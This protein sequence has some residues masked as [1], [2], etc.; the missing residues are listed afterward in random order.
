MRTL[1]PLAKASVG[2]RALSE[3]KPFRWSYLLTFPITVAAIWV[4][5]L[6]LAHVERAQLL[7][8]LNARITLGSVKEA[9]A[10][11]R[12][13]GRMPEPPLETFVAAAASPTRQ[14]AQEAQ[15]AISE[16]LRKWQRQLNADRNVSRVAHRL[17]RLAATLDAHRDSF[18]IRDHPWL[19]K[20]TER[21]VRLANTAPPEDALGLAVHCESLL[22]MT[23]GL[24]RSAPSDVI[25]VASTAAEF[26]PDRIFSPPSRLALE[27]L[28]AAEDAALDPPPG[29]NADRSAS[30]GSGSDRQD[31]PSQRALQGDS[32]DSHPRSFYRQHGAAAGKASPISI[33]DSPTEA[34]DP[35]ATID[36]RVL[37]ERWL[38]DS[39]MPKLRIERELERRGFGSLRTDVVRLALSD[40]TNGRALLV[41]D[42]IETPG[43]GAKAWLLLLAADENAEVRLAAVTVMATS[44]DAELIE[45]AWQVALHDHDPRIAGLAERLRDR[46]ASAQ[47]R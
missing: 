32:T 6:V 39:G 5:F 28:L 12:Q 2:A 4:V 41:H 34:V 43:V 11:L 25:P 15:L 31:R 44:N 45:M 1:S 16:L 46:R 30:V 9:K 13:I 42:L 18:T 23:N 8:E 10:A 29:I 22:S 36:S 24:S 17:E 21:I 27:S 47:R 14:V 40:D 26:A 37:L 20:T 3:V 38:A 33:G 35:W 19:A 7:D